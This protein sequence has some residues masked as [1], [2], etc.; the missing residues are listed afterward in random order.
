MIDDS[1][2][3]VEHYDS[4]ESVWGHPELKAMVASMAGAVAG[5]GQ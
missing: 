1:V 5:V 2:W 3:Q 4:V